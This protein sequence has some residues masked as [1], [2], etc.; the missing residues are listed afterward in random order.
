MAI[1]D[2]KVEDAKAISDLLGQLGY[3]KKSEF[4]AENLKKIVNDGKYKGIVYEKENKVVAFITM[5]FSVQIGYEGE[6][7]TISYFIVDENARSKGIGKEME[8]YCTALA[9][10]RKCAYMDLYSNAKRTD[11]HRFY[12]RQGYT[13]YE[14]YFMKEINEK[15]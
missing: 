8:E 2:I 9:K 12:E 7:L 4:I 11:A 6:V 3:P 10:K 5:Y 14:K 1:R 15:V 13:S